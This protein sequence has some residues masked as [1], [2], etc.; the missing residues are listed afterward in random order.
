MTEA[1]CSELDP[2]FDF[3]SLAQPV[4]EDARAKI[5]APEALA[6]QAVRS[7]EATARHLARMPAQL[8]HVLSLVERG[9]LRIRT[10]SPDADARWGRV[11][12]GINR[13]CLSL[14]T[15]A[16]LISGAIYLVSGQHPIHIALGAAAMVGA[17][18]LG[19]VVIVGALRPGQV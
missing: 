3:R 12:R 7:I 9:G 17:V 6:Q 13:L 4:L 5:L 1:I 19:L 11:G 16:L 8:G 2:T 14:L 18:L 10:E 15:A